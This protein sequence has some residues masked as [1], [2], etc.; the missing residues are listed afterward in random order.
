MK[1]KGKVKVLYIAGTARSGSTHLGNIISER[2]DFINVGEL[3]YI[4]DRGIIDNW[5]CYCKKSFKQCDS[6]S[7]IISSISK[8][9]GFI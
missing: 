6:W 8:I 5:Q 4:W 9:W 7:S 3:R 1:S 2:Y